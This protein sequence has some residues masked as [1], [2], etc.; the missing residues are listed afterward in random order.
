LFT[1]AQ[2]FAT[3]P[4]VV[5]SAVRPTEPMPFGARP[6]QAGPRRFFV[7]LANHSALVT[8]TNPKEIRN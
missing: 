2:Q 1:I 6:Q 8:E 5:A 3:H 7:T 4:L